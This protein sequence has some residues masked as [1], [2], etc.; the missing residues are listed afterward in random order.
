MEF[1]PSSKDHTSTVKEERGSAFSL[2]ACPA[3]TTTVLPKC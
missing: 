2:G 1:A 3:A